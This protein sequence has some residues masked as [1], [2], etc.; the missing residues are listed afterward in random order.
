MQAST[1]NDGLV[2]SCATATVAV[3]ITAFI[4][5]NICDWLLSEKTNWA[6]S[7]MASNRYN[8]RM[9]WCALKSYWT[10]PGFPSS[11]KCLCLLQLIITRV[12]VVLYWCW[13][14]CAIYSSLPGWSFFCCY[15]LASVKSWLVTHR[16]GQK[17][18]DLITGGYLHCAIQLGTGPGWL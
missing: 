8:H 15:L 6:L 17:W 11:R 7:G 16:T 2:I 1:L 4:V 3:I 5:K 10:I 13:M 18:P 12:T 9:Q 14:A